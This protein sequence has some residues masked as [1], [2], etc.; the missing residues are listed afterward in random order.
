MST[1]PTT[2]A[3][4]LYVSIADACLGVSQTAGGGQRRKA[5]RGLTGRAIRASVLSRKQVNPPRWTMPHPACRGGRA[6]VFAN[7]QPISNRPAGGQGGVHRFPDADVPLGQ[8][9]R[10]SLP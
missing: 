7:V 6:C 2:A 10:Q 3:L 5:G 8:D 4:S 9:T 1:C